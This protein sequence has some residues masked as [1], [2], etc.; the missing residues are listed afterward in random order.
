MWPEPWVSM[1]TSVFGRKWAGCLLGCEDSVEQEWEAAVDFSFHPLILPLLLSPPAGGT[2]L[3][4][5]EWC[6]PCPSNRCLVLT[7]NTE[8]TG[9]N[10]SLWKIRDR[11]GMRFCRH[12][13]TH[14][15]LLKIILIYVAALGLSFSSWDL[16]SALWHVGSSPATKDWNWAPELGAQ[17]TCELPHLSLYHGATHGSKYLY[18]QNNHNNWW[19]KHRGC[20][21]MTV[22]WTTV[23]QGIELTREP[24]N[25][26]VPWPRGQECC[27]GQ[28]AWGRVTSPG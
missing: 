23:D 16:P 18:P 24:S 19:Q 13:H 12:C 6:H 8:G 2:R 25:Q 21:H 11:V 22:L 15:F 3:K 7:P 17:T 5:A 4:G 1:N 10:K 28:E 20:S 9:K 27:L 26:S 14:T